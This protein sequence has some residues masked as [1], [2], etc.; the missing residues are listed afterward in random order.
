MLNKTLMRPVHRDPTSNHILL[1]MVCV[2]N[3]VF[4]DASSDYHN[5]KLDERSSY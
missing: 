4:I 2:K 1:K 3:L 5:L